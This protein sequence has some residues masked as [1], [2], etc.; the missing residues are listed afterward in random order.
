[1][2]AFPVMGRPLDALTGFRFVAAAHVLVLHESVDALP[3]AGPWLNTMLLRTA[4]VSFFFVLSG[5]VLVQAYGDVEWRS[6]GAWRFAVGRLARLYPLYLLGL[7]AYAPFL[8]FDTLA[9]VDA[10]TGAVVA[11]D[12]AP[13]VGRLVGITVT[14]LLLVQAWFPQWACTW[15]CP[16]WSVSATAFFAALF[17]L[18]CLALRGRR[19]RTLWLVLAGAFALSQLGAWAYVHH[20]GMGEV[21]REVFHKNPLVRSP[22]FVL[23]VAAGFLWRRGALRHPLLGHRAALPLL[24]LAVVGLFTL[25]PEPWSPHLHNGLLA[26]LFVL[27]LAASIACRGRLGRLLHHPRTQALGQASFAIY[28]LHIPF[29]RLLAFL[30]WLPTGVY[31]RWSLTF[32]LLDALLITLLAGPVHR[33]VEEPLRRW[34]R[35]RLS[36]ATPLKRT[37]QLAPA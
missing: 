17:P 37:P 28:L 15:N 21:A 6:R 4:A 10:A 8:A 11:V 30:L 14:H 20:T 1:M 31:P 19:R 24:G 16:G 7:L 18:L 35:A 26:P 23:G 27:V 3:D 32:L 29:A 9:T 36:P 13:D 25:L 2:F 5:F 22:E 33:R 12:A 34:L